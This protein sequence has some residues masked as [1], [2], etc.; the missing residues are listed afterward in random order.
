[1]DIIRAET[2]PPKKIRLSGRP[3]HNSQR[4]LP[5]EAIFTRANLF[6]HGG[7]GLKKGGAMQLSSC[8]LFEGLSE[9]QINHLI[10]IGTETHIQT[11]QWLFREGEV[12][13][14]LFILKSGAIELLTTVDDVELPINIVRNEGECF[15]TSTMVSPHQYSLSARCAE[16]AI[17]LCMEKTALDKLLKEDHEVEH[18][19]LANLAKHFLDRLKETRQ[20]LKIHFKTIF[21]SI[22]H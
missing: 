10:T 8:Y 1:M 22:H 11:G 16:N 2:T 6:T 7:S 17:L 21:K 19:I 12:A 9:S 5:S 13:D 18:T 15:G 20:E 3:K 14:N 4:F